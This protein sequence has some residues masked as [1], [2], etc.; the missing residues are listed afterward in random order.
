MRFG[1]DQLDRAARGGVFTAGAPV[2][3]FD[4]PIKIGGYACIQR[5]VP[6]ADDV[7]VP[8]EKRD[9]IHGR[10]IL[11]PVWK[12]RLTPKLSICRRDISAD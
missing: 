1:V 3:V 11:I 10:D 12:I 4:S 9:I 8:G 5:A 7:N 6:A 2:M